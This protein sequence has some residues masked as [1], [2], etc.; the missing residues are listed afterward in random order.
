M[1]NAQPRWLPYSQKQKTG[2]EKQKENASK[3]NRTPNPYRPTTEV[4]L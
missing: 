3:K 4:A 1:T 2:N